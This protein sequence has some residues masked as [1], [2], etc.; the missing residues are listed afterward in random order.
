MDFAALKKHPTPRRP[1][2][3]WTLNLIVRKSFSLQPAFPLTDDWQTEIIKNN[4]RPGGL[5]PAELC[6]L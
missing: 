3:L 5:G 4:K 1:P 2:V 6:C